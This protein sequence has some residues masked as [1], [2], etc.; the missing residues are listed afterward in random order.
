M[1]VESH[2]HVL[3]DRH[4]LEQRRVLKG[5]PQTAGHD[6]VRFETRHWLPM[7]GDRARCGR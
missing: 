7:K 4:I 2:E 6:V 1:Q 5:A 3:Q